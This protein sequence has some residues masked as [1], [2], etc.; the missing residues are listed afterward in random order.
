MKNTQLNN[1]QTNTL[2]DLVSDQIN[3]Q[4]VLL[5][6]TPLLITHMSALTH[7]RHIKSILVAK[8]K[9]EKWIE[10]MEDRENAE[11]YNFFVY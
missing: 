10:R 8:D 5:R 9:E 4:R 2:I 7:L 11:L 6:E 3:I 1:E